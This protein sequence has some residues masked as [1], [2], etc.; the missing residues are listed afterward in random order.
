LLK[1]AENCFELAFKTR[2]VLPKYAVK[3]AFTQINQKQKRY[4]NVN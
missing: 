1:N 4:G 2:E 3:S